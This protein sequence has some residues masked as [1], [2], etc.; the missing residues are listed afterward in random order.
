MRDG[1]LYSAEDL[2]N[3]SLHPTDVVSRVLQFLTRYG[4]A[5]MVMKRQP[6]FRKLA[7]VPAPADSLALLQRIVVAGRNRHKV[8]TAR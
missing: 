4:F 2:A 5:E 3:S 1:D 6:L 7:D 8:E